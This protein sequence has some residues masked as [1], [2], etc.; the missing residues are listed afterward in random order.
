MRRSLS[1]R[2][3]P[4]V[5]QPDLFWLWRYRLERLIRPLAC[6]P[7]LWNEPAP[8]PQCRQACREGRAEPSWRSWGTGLGE[9][10]ICGALAPAECQRNPLPYAAWASNNCGHFRA[11]VGGRLVALE[12][13]GCGALQR[14]RDDLAA[15]RDPW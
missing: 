9:P 6:L 11:G 10:R 4:R 2:G 13:C 8:G 5:Y 14:R 1:D 12:S 15:E 7:G 3:Q